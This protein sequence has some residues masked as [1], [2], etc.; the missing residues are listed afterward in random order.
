MIQHSRFVL[1]HK[2][3]TG[4]EENYKMGLQK[5]LLKMKASDVV[6]VPRYQLATVL[7]AFGFGKI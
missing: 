6:R 3:R 5:A 2:R 7:A 1:M 4:T